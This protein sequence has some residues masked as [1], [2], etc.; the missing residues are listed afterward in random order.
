MAQ[1][2]FP[3]GQLG[4]DTLSMRRRNSPIKIKKDGRNDEKLPQEGRIAGRKK[5]FKKLNRTK[6]IQSNPNQTKRLPEKERMKGV[7]GGKKV[8]DLETNDIGTKDIGEVIGSR[9]VTRSRV[10][11]RR[12]ET[13]YIPANHSQ[14]LLLFCHLSQF[15]ASGP[16]GYARALVSLLPFCLLPALNPKIRKAQP[17]RRFRWG[18]HCR[19]QEPQVPVIWTRKE[20]VG[21]NPSRRE[22]EKNRMWVSRRFF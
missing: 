13:I 7:G 1:Y 8:T 17:N 21:R 6:T 4:L 2:Q 19:G 11:E 14:G 22:P 9:L 10:L 16:Q 5:N 18:L 3:Q 20:H 15:H 12:V